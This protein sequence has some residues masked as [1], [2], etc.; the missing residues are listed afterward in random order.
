M[1]IH[2]K[3]AEI[4][5]LSRLVPW[6]QAYYGFDRIPF[7]QARVTRALERLL[8]DASL[9]RVWIIRNDEQDAGYVVL[10]FGYDLEFGGRQA[11]ITEIYLDPEHRRS[12]LGAATF[13]F[14]EDFCYTH[15]VHALELQ[16][17]QENIA[18]QSFY[19]KLG[20]QKHDRIPMSK[21]IA[22][23]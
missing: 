23:D 17:E 15:G 7:D 3:T 18:A 22:R 4:A 5:D 11:T 6:I 13:K 9:G 21:W 10:T 19:Q 12:G 1:S 8:M 16:V 2:F 20:F 14:L